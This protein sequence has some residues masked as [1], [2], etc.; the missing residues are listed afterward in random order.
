MSGDSKAPDDAR[1]DGFGE[2]SAEELPEGPWWAEE[3]PH[4][5]PEP[6]AQ[7]PVAPPAAAPVAASTP[8]RSPE[9]GSVAPP[10]PDDAQHAESS[11]TVRPRPSAAAFTT[12]AMLRPVSRVPDSGWRRVAH[13]LTFGLWS[14]P[15]SQAE[16]EFQQSIARVKQP[17]AGSRRIAVIS[18]K[19]GV[20]KTTTTLMLGH[21]FAAHR[22]DRVVALD[23]NPDAGSLG[24]RVPRQTAA[25]VTDLLDAGA[26]TQRYAD[27]RSYTSQ[28]STRLEVIAADDDPHMTQAIGED[29][30]TAAIELLERHYNL[31]LLDTGTGVLHSAMRGIL[32]AADQLVLVLVPSLD[33]ARAAS[34]TLDWLEEQ[35]R[36]ELVRGCVAVL[37][38]AR[39]RGLVDV[40]RIEAHFRNRVRATVRVPWDP[41]LE[42]GAESSLEQLRPATR[43]VYV[44][45]AAAVADGFS[46][47]SPRRDAAEP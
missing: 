11:A 40:D 43:D 23:G 22:G 32:D 7:H 42:A 6:A 25:T 14:P 4:A 5:A 19:G 37:N 45:L 8:A 3:D 39:D 41:H 21:T 36:S 28:A 20:G 15:P 26:D 13:R 16:I 46:L 35:G 31:I 24:Y 9:P 27:M 29:E 38:Q 34:L 33:G 47:P 12:E 10:A 1:N 2:A 18:R 30:Y 44:E 17:V